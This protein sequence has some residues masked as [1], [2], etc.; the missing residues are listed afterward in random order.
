[1]TKAAGVRALNI[2]REPVQ[3]DDG[4]GILARGRS[5]SGAGG[6]INDNRRDKAAFSLSG[7]RLAPP[8]IEQAD[9]TRAIASRIY[10][11]KR[12]RSERT[13]RRYC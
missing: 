1:M 13:R 7:Q 3:F 10:A 8:P 5:R 12:C 11:P 4:G 9:V 6:F 2:T